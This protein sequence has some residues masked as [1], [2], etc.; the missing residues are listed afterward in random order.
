MY[1]GTDR[2]AKHYFLSYKQLP[3]DKEKKV[4]IVDVTIGL[5]LETLSRAASETTKPNLDADERG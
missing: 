2:S 5:K 3:S 4:E 1:R